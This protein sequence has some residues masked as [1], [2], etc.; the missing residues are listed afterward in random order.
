M[1]LKEF[2]ENLKDI[3][4]LGKRYQAA[5]TDW[6]NELMRINKEKAQCIKDYLSLQFHKEHGTQ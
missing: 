4:E 1:N 6:D 2:D 3:F 5:V